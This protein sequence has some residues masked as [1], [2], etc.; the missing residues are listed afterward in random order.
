MGQDEED[1]S[2]ESE[3]RRA[4]LRSPE[5]WAGVVVSCDLVFFFGVFLKV[6]KV[7]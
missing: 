2:D 6:F 4:P 3:R 1:S 7:V 5:V